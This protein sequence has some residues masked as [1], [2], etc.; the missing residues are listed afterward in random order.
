MFV[1]VEVIRAGIVGDIQ[2]GPA[3]VVVIAPDH[4]QAV[5]FVGVV[6]AGFLGNFFKRAIAAIVKQQVGFAQHAPRA[7]LHRDSLEAAVLLIFAEVGQFVHVE[8]HV[9]GDEQVHMAVAVVVAPGRAGAESSRHHSCLIRDIFKLAV[10]QVVIQRIAAIASYVDIG[11]T[12]VVIV[13]DC[14][15]HAPAFAGESGGLGDVGEFE[16]VVLVIER[17]QRIAALLVAIDGGSVHRDDVE[18]AV[19]VAIDQTR[20]PAHRFDDVALFGR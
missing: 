1:V 4:A 5:V 12:I 7:A 17:D 20:A 6:D 11:Q 8:M 19:V 9:A 13:G 3:V 18:F 10:A 15:S 14:D 2:V 16:A